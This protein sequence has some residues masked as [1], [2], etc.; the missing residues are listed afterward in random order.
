MLSS[1][2]PK[3]L[4]YNF[5]FPRN[6]ILS[7]AI[8]NRLISASEVICPIDPCD[9]LKEGNF[10]KIDLTFFPNTTSSMLLPSFIL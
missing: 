4:N 5:S 6:G 1:T 7:Q 2:L 10:V 8:R 9:P 3:R